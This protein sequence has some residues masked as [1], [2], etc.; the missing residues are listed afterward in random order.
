MPFQLVLRKGNESECRNRAKE[1]GSERAPLVTSPTLFAS[2]HCARP[3]LNKTIRAGLEQHQSRLIG[4]SPQ[5][6]DRRV[7]VFLPE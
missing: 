1:G 5:S 2:L 4:H 7:F 6:G 3:W